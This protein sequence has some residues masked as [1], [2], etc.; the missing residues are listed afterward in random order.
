[1]FSFPFDNIREAIQDAFISRGH[2]KC[3]EDVRLLPKMEAVC[4]SETL[5]PIYQA[6]GCQILDDIIFN[7]H[8]HENF[9]ISQ[10][11]FYSLKISRKKSQ[12]GHKH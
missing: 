9:K 10:K 4:C 3:F 7:S 1:M 8:H 12:L 5:V 6:T 11:W 2:T